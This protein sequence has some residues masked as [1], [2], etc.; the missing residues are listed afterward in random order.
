MKFSP[1]LFPLAYV[2]FV[3]TCPRAECEIYGNVIARTT[4]LWISPSDLVRGDVASCCCSPLIIAEYERTKKE[5]SI[6]NAPDGA[7]NLER[8]AERRESLDCANLSSVIYPF[9]PRIDL[10][11]FNLQTNVVG[12]TYA[13]EIPFAN[14]IP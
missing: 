4:R 12:Q 10:S 14:A 5:C 13:N 3:R 1:I 7:A 11:I 9:L 6:V 8:E 2:L